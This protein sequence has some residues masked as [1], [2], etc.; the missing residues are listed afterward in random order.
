MIC[1]N[2]ACNY[3]LSYGK[4]TTDRQLASI[5][6]IFNLFVGIDW[7]VETFRVVGKEEVKGL[8]FELPKV[9]KLTIKPITPALKTS[10]NHCLP[11]EYL[12]KLP[13]AKFTNFYNVEHFHRTVNFV[14]LN[15]CMRVNYDCIYKS[16][17]LLTAVVNIKKFIAF[18]LAN[19]I[20]EFHYEETD[21][22]LQLNFEKGKVPHQIRICLWYKQA[23]I[24]LM[25]PMFYQLD[26]WI[27][28]DLIS[29]RLLKVIGDIFYIFLGKLPID[30]VRF[31]L[32]EAVVPVE[33]CVHPWEDKYLT[34]DPTPIESRRDE[35]SGRLGK[36]VVDIIKA[37]CNGDKEVVKNDV[38]NLINRYIDKYPM[39]PIK[40]L[41]SFGAAALYLVYGKNGVYLASND[42]KSWSNMCHCPSLSLFVS[43]VFELE[44]FQLKGKF[45]SI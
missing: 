37:T 17:L 22:S 29:P 28:S 33:N 10:I 2:N 30:C 41:S 12:A 6:N 9:K 38:N 19:K 14:W 20:K 34:S 11:S 23:C 35:C 18:D 7:S 8:F 15:E 1:N 40:H 27:R 24:L 4:D 16:K 13:E 32:T 26:D 36:W 45:I 3:L 39:L 25:S 42:F 43:Y 31:E 44:K 5:E 21:A